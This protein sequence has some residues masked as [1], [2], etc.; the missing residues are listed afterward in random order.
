M[1]FVSKLLCL[2]SSSKLIRLLKKSN[3]LRP[4]RSKYEKQLNHSIKCRKER[5]FKIDSSTKKWNLSKFLFSLIAKKFEQLIRLSGKK[6]IFRRVK[7]AVEGRF[8]PAT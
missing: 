4:N 6:Q 8:K 2:E 3:F 5:F 1:C 7:E